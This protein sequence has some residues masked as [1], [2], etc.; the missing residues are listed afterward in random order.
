[1]SEPVETSGVLGRLRQ[2]A[3]GV[4]LASILMTVEIDYAYQQYY[5][6]LGVSLGDLGLSQTELIYRSLGLLVVTAVIIIGVILLLGLALSRGTRIGLLGVVVAL[7]V[8]FVW[9]S[10]VQSID[11]AVRQVET[12][13]ELPRIQQFGIPILLTNTYYVQTLE[14]K[15]PAY[16][17]T[18][19]YKKTNNMPLTLM[20]LRGED[21]KSVL[22]YDYQTHRSVVRHDVLTLCTGR[23]HGL[24]HSIGDC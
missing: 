13:A 21:D 23:L 11:G 8:G 18:L 15:D 9:G 19:D 10:A 7:M 16:Q 4:S 3:G 2:F 24:G 22:L 12:G 20:Y 1:M 17:R 6:R 5:K 14:V